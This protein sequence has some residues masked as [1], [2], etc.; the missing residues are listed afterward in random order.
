M[1][2]RTDFDWGEG[3][4]DTDTAPLA[5]FVGAFGGVGVA[6]DHLQ[7]GNAPISEQARPAALAMLAPHSVE[8]HA[9]IDLGGL[10]QALAGCGAAMRLHALE[11]WREIARRA[12]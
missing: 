12:P 5:R 8:R 2:D 1:S 6:V 3:V 9:M 7:I 10:A 11:Q 4:C